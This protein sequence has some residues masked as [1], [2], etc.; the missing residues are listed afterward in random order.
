LEHQQGCSLRQSFLF[1]PQFPL[2]LF[3]VLS[4]LSQLLAIGLWGQR[5]MGL[6][7]ELPPGIYLLGE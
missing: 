7:A 4:L 5:F 1:S 6:L 2:Q 3:D